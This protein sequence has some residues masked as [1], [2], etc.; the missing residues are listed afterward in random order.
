MKIHNI[1]SSIFWF[2]I[3][4]VL[5]VVVGFA[6]YYTGYELSFSLFYLIPI[7]VA[8]WFSSKKMGFIMSI[9]ATVLWFFIDYISD[10]KYSS[11]II[12][13]WNAIIRFGIFCIVSY[14]LPSLKE[15]TIAREHARV[16]PLTGAFNRRYFEE[17]LQN[18]ISRIAR[19]KNPF[20]LILFDLD[21]FKKINDFNGHHVGDQVLCT[22]VNCA[23]GILRKTDIITRLGGDEFAILLFEVNVVTVQSMVEKIKNKLLNEMK[24]NNWPITFSM[25]VVTCQS[26]TISIDDLIKRADSLMYSIKNNGKNG[27]A[28]HTISANN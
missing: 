24:I 26:S 6:D 11:A 19:N 20:T 25:G 1:K 4:L 10:H 21:G 15:L 2:F 8:A 5:I 28:Y 23:N 12:P 7:G 18:E 17:V 9:I 16:D 22:I 3:G 13:Y 14:L 27:V